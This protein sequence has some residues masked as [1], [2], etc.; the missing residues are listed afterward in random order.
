MYLFGGSLLMSLWHASPLLAL[1]R[2]YVFNR[3]RPGSL[4]LLPLLPFKEF[5]E[6]LDWELRANILNFTFR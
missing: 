4:V 6:E 1:D 5:I 3:G 2:F